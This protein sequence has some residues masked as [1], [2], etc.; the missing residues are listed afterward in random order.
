MVWHVAHLTHTN[1]YQRKFKFCPETVWEVIV[2]YV[3][4]LASKGEGSLI[5]KLCITVAECAEGF[6]EVCNTF[7][8]LV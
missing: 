7:I 4:L 8:G 3:L 5:S 1:T 6:K 2:S